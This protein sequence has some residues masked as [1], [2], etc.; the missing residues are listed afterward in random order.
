[1]SGLLNVRGL[2]S[3]ACV[4]LGTLV[5]TAHA[6]I[7][8]DGPNQ[9]MIDPASA[10]VSA[11]LTAKS[12]SQ[13]VDQSGLSSGY[14]NGTLAEEYFAGSPVHNSQVNSNLYFSD[15]G[16][17]TTG[18]VDFD[19]G[20]TWD[21]VDSFTLWSYGLGDASQIDEFTLIAD[22][23]GDFS[24]GSTVIG[25]FNNPLYGGSL[26]TVPASTVS[27]SAVEAS[28][29]R[30]VISSNHGNVVTL[31]SEAAFTRATPE[32]SSFAMLGI[33]G[34]FGI[35]VHRRRRRKQRPVVAD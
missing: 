29:V 18:S 7:I 35:G 22:D 2:C 9:Y 13:T 24:A 32:P 19:L 33:A 26:T 15:F 16:D 30:M 25:T 11:G 8:N 23:D 3:V 14:T 27:F 17:P 4:L 6:A 5:S 1:M 10:T 20:G 34:V 28:F 12:A 21:D 31:F